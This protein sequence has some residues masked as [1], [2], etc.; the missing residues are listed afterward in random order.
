MICLCGKSVSECICDKS[1][2]KFNCLENIQLALN[3]IG[4]GFKILAENDYE[5][6]K[7]IKFKKKNKDDKNSK[8]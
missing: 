2:S 5:L 4:Y 6:P 3:C 1:V 8:K 7:N